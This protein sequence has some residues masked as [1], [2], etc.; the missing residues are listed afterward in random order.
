MAVAAFIFFTPMQSDDSFGEELDIYT[1]SGDIDGEYGC[2]EAAF[3][4]VNEDIYGK[5][6]IITVA[7]HDPEICSFIL[8]AGKTV[9]LRSSEGNTCILKAATGERHGVVFGNLTLEN[10]ILDGNKNSGGIVVKTNASLTMNNGAK[11]QNCYFKGNGGAVSSEGAFTMNS[12]S[13]LINNKVSGDGR[14]QSLGTE[15]A[16]CGGAVYIK[17]GTFALN[18]GSISGN[19]AA[20]GAGVYNDNSNFTMEGGVISGNLGKAPSSKGYHQG[21]GVGVYNVNNS[22]F[23]M[24][25][26]EITDNKLE[27]TI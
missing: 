12:G 10:I 14:S 8:N 17:N 20:C 1:V 22:T 15:P 25:G 5:E 21:G 26:G 13:A 3:D 9:T 27:Y 24:R 4:A 2:L 6:Y 19:E 18:G 16:G 11:I 7:E 23:T